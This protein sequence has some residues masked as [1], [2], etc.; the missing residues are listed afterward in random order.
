M[1]SVTYVGHKCIPKN[2]LDVAKYF[3]LG[4]LQFFSNLIEENYSSNDEINVNHHEILIIRSY[5]FQKEM[6][7]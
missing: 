4:K 5:K 7:F 3:F 6:T 2:R 1:S